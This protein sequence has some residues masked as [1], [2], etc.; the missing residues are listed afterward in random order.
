MKCTRERIDYERRNQIFLQKEKNY[1]QQYSHI[2]LKRL[3]ALR[4]RVKPRLSSLASVKDK[5]ISLQVGEEV[6]VVGTLYKEQKLKPNALD[7]FS[8]DFGISVKH[9]LSNYFSEDDT[10]VLEDESGRCLLQGAESEQET[11]KNQFVSY[12]VSGVVVGC[13]GVLNEVGKFVVSKMVFPGDDLAPP[14]A[15]LAQGSPHPRYLMIASGLFAGSTRE[16][17]TL[18]LELLAEYLGGELGGDSSAAASSI[19]RLVVAGGGIV[20]PPQLKQ[21]L[22]GKVSSES[23]ELLVQPLRVADQ[24]LAELSSKVPIDLMPGEHDPCNISLPQQPLHQC[25]FPHSFRLS[26]SSFN[27]VTNPHAFALQDDPSGEP[28]HAIGH[29]GQPVLDALRYTK[30]STEFG[31][32]D[33]L[34]ACILKYRHLAPT[35]PDTLAC[36]PFHDRD[37]FVVD[38]DQVRLHFAGSMPRF[39]TDFAQGM[40]FVCVPS[41]HDTKQVV[42]VD[43]SSP[44]LDTR[45]LSFDVHL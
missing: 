13:V 32:L 27:C 40:R 37:P 14:R 39:E 28:L 34:K 45:V 17:H 9:N 35:A 23:Q 11:W 44:T 31:P 10:L 12:L 42:L 19:V 24:Y 43:V 6:G 20:P 33:F 3:L 4:P 18:C 15:P 30:P 22:D 1:I 25:L 8:H 41:F 26:E 29:S 2:Y 36:Y 38:N 21:S 5:V 16:D 7:E